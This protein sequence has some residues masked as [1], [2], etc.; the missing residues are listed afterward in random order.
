MNYHK[1]R[2]GLAVENGHTQL[3]ITQDNNATEEEQEQ[4]AKLWKMVLDGMK[5]LLE[6]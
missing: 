2:Y 6:G 1:V 3:T 4:N 5:K